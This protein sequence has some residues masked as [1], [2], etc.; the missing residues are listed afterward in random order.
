MLEVPVFLINGFLESGKTTLIK[1]VIEHDSKLQKLNTL[2][3]VC[4]SKSNLC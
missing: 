3:V 2:L 4:E 1:N